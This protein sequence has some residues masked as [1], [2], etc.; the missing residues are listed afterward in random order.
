M[1]PKKIHYCWFGGEKP[2][3]VKECIE[4]WH[5]ILTDYEIIE[6]NQEN[7][8]INKLKYTREAFKEKK[9]A[10]V[11]DVARVYALYQYGGIY[12]DTDVKVYK[13]FDSILKEKCVFGFEEGLY[14]A[15]SFMACEAGHSV[16]KEF[17]KLYVDLDFHKADGNINTVTN[18]TKLTKILLD[19][20]LQRKDKFQYLEDGIIIY[21]QEYFSPYDYSNC[22]HHNTENTICEHLFFVSWMPW[23]TR[24]KKHIKSIIGPALGKDKMNLLRSVVKRKSKTKEGI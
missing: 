15:T 9:Y 23:M 24:V 13:K 7:F 6:W 12:L 10:F 3:T 11:S 4:S 17:M 22:I 21:P 19:K 16:M 5:N 8:D 14:I 1:I 20:G 2:D 18:V